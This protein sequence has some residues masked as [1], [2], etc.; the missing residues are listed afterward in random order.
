MHQRAVHLT[1]LDAAAADLDLV[2]GA[3]DEIQPVGL[4]P[5]Q[6]AAAVGAAPGKRRHRGVLL[7]VLVGIEVARQPHPADDELADLP[8]VH[9]PAVGADDRQIPPGQGQADADRSPPE[10]PRSAG[11]H[12]RFGRAVGVPHLAALHREPLGEFGRAGLAAEDQQPHR[13]QGLR[14]PQR[15]QRRHGR[16]HRDVA[17]HQPGAQVHPAAHQRAR[18][19]HQTRAV[20]PRQPHLLTGGVERHRQS[21][22][23]PVSGAQRVVLQ[24]HPRLGVDEGGGAAMADRDTLGRTGGAGGEDDPRVV[25]AQRCCGAPA[26]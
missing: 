13:L 18:G 17:R 10:Q 1:E 14:R 11:H 2:V 22:Q 21:R 12:G 7:G 5:D 16:D 3:T 9:R 26:A 23:H 19:G 24:E 25:A 4:Q 20:P 6:V 8:E 15:R